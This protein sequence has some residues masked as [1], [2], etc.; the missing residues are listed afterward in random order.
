L[1]SNLRRIDIN[2]QIITIS[3]IVIFPT[4]QEGNR[5]I[6]PAGFSVPNTDELKADTIDSGVSNTA[7][8]FSSFLRLP[9]AGSRNKFD[10]G[11][12]NLGSVAFLWSWK[13]NNTTDSDY[14]RIEVNSLQ[15]RNQA[16]SQGGSI[17]CIKDL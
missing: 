1:V 5:D 7:T 15:I 10:G 4:P 14:L 11:L 12:N 6:C 9:A 8:A 3:S 13:D 17:R 16:R 2:P